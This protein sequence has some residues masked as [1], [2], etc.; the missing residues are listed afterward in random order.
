MTLELGPEFESL[1]EY[2]RESRGV[3]FSGYKRASLVRR[4]AKRCSELGI[5]TFATY[6]DYLQVHADEFPILFDKVLINVTE[7]FRDPPAWDHL[8]DTILPRIIAKSGAIRVWST[9]TAS[10]EEA[11]SIAILLC[12]ALGP[13]QFLRRVKIYAT[14]IDEQALNKARAGYLPKDVESLD[15]ATRTKYFEQQGSR[16]LFRSSLRRALIF[17]RHDLMQDAPISRLD[18]L[19][20]RNTLMYFTSE[21]QGRVLA[22][23]HYA[24]NDEGYLFLG[25]AEMLLTHSAL[26]VPLDPKQRIFAKVARVQLRERLMLLAQSGSAEA[27]NHV[28]R[29]VRE[30]ATEGVP[31]P[32]LVI[33]ALGV[34]VSANQAARRM[35]GLRPGDIGRPL[36]DLD[37][38]FKP[39]DLRSPIERVYRERRPYTASG[40]EF[41]MPDGG[42]RNY[43]V[44]VTPLIDDDGSIA[45][46]SVAF[47][48]V[49]NVTQL[50]AELERS[51]QDVETAYEELQS[52]NEELET[53]NEE[54]Q[55]TVEELETTNAELQSSNE[56]LETMNEELEST[57]SA[58]NSINTDLRSRTDEVNKLN[59]FLRAVTGSIE[60]GAIVLDGETKVQVWNE[61]AADLWGLRSDEVVG[62]AF[63]DLDIGLPAK[64]LRNM[65]RAVLR[66]KPAHDEATVEALSRRGRSIQ[67]RVIAYALSDG[68]QPGGVVL[69]MEELTTEKAR[70]S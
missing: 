5:D 16:F 48:D 26:F 69:V 11:Y 58:L 50:R 15:E 64:D 13:E 46:T 1:I 25:R 65:I 31:N 60:L 30:L 17:G 37:L 27:A 35:F 10:G 38:S 24:L 44:H 47:M 3:D 19:I 34:T 51:K 45:G 43:D 20:C 18:L 54:L 23:F 22:R 52:S 4:V 55:S 41:P 56:E 61:R 2:L 70:R 28:V 66:G 8:R 7:F 36:K 12:E 57:N 9:G 29:R 21:T 39:M 6:L 59:T 62:R 67:V 42:V 32:Q 68:E 53:T 14:D 33:D 40:V 63:F 49:T